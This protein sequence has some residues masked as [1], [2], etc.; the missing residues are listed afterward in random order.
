MRKN[1][2]RN[3]GDGIISGMSHDPT[4]RKLNK[5]EPDSLQKSADDPFTEEHIEKLSDLISPETTVDEEH[6]DTSRLDLN[7]GTD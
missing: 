2:A 1:A 4:T 3:I 6:Q 7:E 5:L